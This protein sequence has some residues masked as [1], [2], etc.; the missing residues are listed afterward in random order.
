MEVG[1]VSMDLEWFKHKDYTEDYIVTRLLGEG[2]FGEVSQPQPAMMAV[3]L[4]PCG[5]CPSVRLSVCPSVRPSLS[6]CFSVSLPLCLYASMPLCLSVSLSVY[7]LL[8]LCQAQSCERGLCSV[9]AGEA[10]GAQGD[11]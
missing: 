3:T 9:G 10:G 7:F 8:L 2:S 6:L 4:C 11:A 5:L 1:G